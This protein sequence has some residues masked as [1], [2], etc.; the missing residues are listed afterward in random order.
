MMLISFSCKL[1]RLAQRCHSYRAFSLDLGIFD[2][3]Y[4]SG[5]FH[6]DLRFFLGF[7]KK[8]TVFLGVFKFSREIHIFQWFLLNSKWF[9]QKKEG[10][11][12]CFLSFWSI[13]G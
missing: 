6:G 4:G 12:C 2:P 10:T 1:L 7:F 5:F 3:T 11:S 8:A 9:M 13:K